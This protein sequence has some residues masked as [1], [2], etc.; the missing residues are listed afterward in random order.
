MNLS[1]AS[2]VFDDENEADR[3]VAE[4]RS[5]GVPDSAL[6]IIAQEGRKTTTTDATGA[7]TDEHGGS[8]I[9]GLIGGGALGTGLGVAALAIPGVGPL[10]GLGAIAAS[11][12][13][14][15]MLIGGALGAAAGGLGEALSKHGISDDDVSYY[16]DRMKTGATLVS[17]NSTAPGVTSQAIREILYRNGGHNATQSRMAPAY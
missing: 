5:A 6:S 9:R 7:V 3:A 10:V 16:G 1:I 11:A 14:E 8:I 12:V 15:A 13:P 17:V 4:L 2:A